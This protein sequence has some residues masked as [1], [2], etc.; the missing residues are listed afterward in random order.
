MHLTPERPATRT[1]KTTLFRNP[2]VRV[3]SITDVAKTAA[4]GTV[5]ET[6][7]L[8]ISYMNGLESNE[9]DCV[10]NARRAGTSPPPM[11]GSPIIALRR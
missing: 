6:L 9:W 2:R 5:L 10:E 11:R 4:L 3:K 7:L 8:D 1:L